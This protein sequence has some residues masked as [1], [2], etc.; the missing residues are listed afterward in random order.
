MTY[1][2]RAIRVRHKRYGKAARPVAGLARRRRQRRKRHEKEDRP[3]RI[4]RAGHCVLCAGSDDAGNRAAHPRLLR[5]RG[6]VPVCDRA[7]A[8]AGAARLGGRYRRVRADDPHRRGF[9][10]DRPAERARVY[11]ERPVRRVQRFDGVA[12]YHGI[13]A[14]GGH[15]KERTSQPHR[16]RHPFA[17]PAD[18]YGRGRRHDVY[19]YGAQPADPVGQREGQPADP[20]RNFHH[21]RNEN[22]A[23]QQTGARP[24]YGLLPA[25]VSGRQRVYHRL[26]LCVGHVRVHYL[27][28][29]VAGRAGRVVQFRQLAGGRRRLVCGAAGRHVRLLRRR[30][31]AEGKAGLL[32]D[33]L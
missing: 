28:R 30:M 22:Q 23:A 5:L 27:L 9:P 31:Q 13:R 26:G 1:T 14:F 19:R 20:V 4:P 11:H 6:R 29:T 10:Q 15:R 18:V 24:V 16:H 3:D 32:Q 33:V 12:D 25:R 21:R 2:G 17:F 7:A 8:D